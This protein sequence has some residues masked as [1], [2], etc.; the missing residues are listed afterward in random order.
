[1]CRNCCIYKKLHPD[2]LIKF[3]INKQVVTSLTNAWELGRI[4]VGAD[5]IRRAWDN[6]EI[7]YGE[8]S[9]YTDSLRRLVIE[10]VPVYF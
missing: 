2:L 10:G 5:D 1:M 6:G 8:E 3:G 7:V 9:E 4:A